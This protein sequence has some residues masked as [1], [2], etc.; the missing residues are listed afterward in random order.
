M[1]Y[2]RWLVIATGLLLIGGAVAV[3]D[4]VVKIGPT[5]RESGP[6]VYSESTPMT[7]DLSPLVAL[8]LG[9]ALVSL[10]LLK[11]SGAKPRTGRDDRIVH[12][13]LRRSWLI[14]ITGGSAGCFAG[15]SP[16][17]A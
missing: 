10:A 9:L 14:A 5:V 7:V 12:T 2:L 4:K 15:G 3:L 17:T 11:M 16:A 6:F 13:R 8:L 1:R